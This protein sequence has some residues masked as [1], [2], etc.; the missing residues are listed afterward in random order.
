[1]YGQVVV[2]GELSPAHGTLEARRLPLWDGAEWYVL[3]RPVTGRQ[4]GRGCFWKYTTQWCIQGGFLVA[5]KSPPPAMIF[6]NQAVTP[7]LTPAFTSNLNLRILE[8][9]M[10]PTLDRPLCARIF[11]VSHVCELRSTCIRSWAL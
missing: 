7:L 9:P 6:L 5:R 2:M 3:V 11:S 1:M 8:T 10:R 4:L